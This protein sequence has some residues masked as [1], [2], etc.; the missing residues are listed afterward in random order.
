MVVSWADAN[1]YFQIHSPSVQCTNVNICGVEKVSGLTLNPANVR[2]LV[3]EGGCAYV[4][5]PLP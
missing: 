5:E 1:S 2:V 3:L 4:K